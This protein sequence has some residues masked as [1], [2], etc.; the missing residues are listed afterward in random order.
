MDLRPPAR[1]E[2]PTESLLHPLFIFS[3][4]HKI[5]AKSL[6]QKQDHCSH[7]KVQTH[8][9]CHNQYCHNCHTHNQTV[10]SNPQLLSLIYSSPTHLTTIA[11]YQRW[12]YNV[13]IV[14]GVLSY[15]HLIYFM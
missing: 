10:H 13:E 6:L 14:A 2:V 3:H 8:N 7:H 5:V 4:K 11:D 9:Y 12:N 1:T 15:L